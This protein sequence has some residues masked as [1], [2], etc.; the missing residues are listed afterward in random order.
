MRFTECEGGLDAIAGEHGY[1]DYGIRLT[2]DN[3]CSSN[4]PGMYFN[5]KG[6]RLYVH[7]ADT[8]GIFGDHES[9]VIDSCYLSF[10]FLENGFDDTKPQ[11]RTL[12]GSRVILSIHDTLSY[13]TLRAH[14]R[15][16]IHSS[17]DNLLEADASSTIKVKY[18]FW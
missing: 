14:R 2:S 16:M 17:S 5:E 1:M 8:A 13:D 9:E 4:K 11:I 6:T 7:Y 10:V 3:A 12:G 18:A 15:D